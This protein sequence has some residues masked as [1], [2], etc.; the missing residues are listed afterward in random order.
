[1]LDR[2]RMLARWD[3]PWWLKV[4]VGVAVFALVLRWPV[5]AVPMVVLCLPLIVIGVREKQR[6]RR[7]GEP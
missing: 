2:L 3:P 6:R 7:E 5:L 1:M 4:P